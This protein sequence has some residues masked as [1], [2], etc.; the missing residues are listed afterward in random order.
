MLNRS[1][2][3]AAWLPIFIMIVFVHTTAFA[4]Q[5][6]RLIDKLSWRTEPIK[7][8]R[9]K[10]KNKTLELGKKFYADD[11]WLSGLTVTAQNISQQAIAR[12][13]LTL[14][15]P[16]PK[17]S[18]REKPTLVVPMI[19][20]QDPVVASS[21]EDLKLI[22]P[23]ERVEIELLESNIPSIREDIEKLGY[24]KTI[25]HAQVRVRSVIFVDGSEWIGDEVLYPNPNNPKERINPNR[26]IP[27]RDPP[28]QDLSLS[29]RSELFTFLKVGVNRTSAHPRHIYNRIGNFLLPQLPETLPCDSIHIENYTTSCGPVGEGCSY[30]RDLFV[31]SPLPEDIWQVNARKETIQTRCRKSN[32]TECAPLPILIEQRLPCNVRIAGT[33]LAIS[34]WITYPLTGC[35]TGLFFQGPC[36]RSAAFRSKCDEY[37]DETCSCTGGFMSPVVI[38]V[39][40]SGF[41]MT[42]AAG[43][44][45]FNFL[46]DGVPLAISWT[47]PASTNAFLVLDRNGNGTID[48]GEELFGDVTPQPS[49]SDP[50]GF[51]ALA[52]Y[53][54]LAGGGNGNGRID[55]GDAIFP[56]LRLWQDLNH[57]AISEPDELRTAGALGI[58][59]IDLDYK[60][61]KKTDAHGN[62]FR[63]RARVFD[64]NGTH[65]GRWAWDVFLKF[66]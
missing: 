6:E 61:S 17:E 16:P 3:K 29:G 34:D 38:D 40:R 45:V 49:S 66:Q 1:N 9:I 35:I 18:S 53:D 50:N 51:L 31:A 32:G 4:Q 36:T 26:Q 52:V 56:Q 24:E 23:G 5:T 10:T 22:N 44:V 63:Y 64:V 19:F 8:E 60:E 33:C 28:Q 58:S 14:A 7:I 15:F 42:D 62:N 2:E 59:G 20:G 12:I 48:N 30:S 46:N 11:D 39:D 27:N 55:S 25:K 21:A 43:G 57:N 41:S 37:E 47:A 54:T 65:A 13:E